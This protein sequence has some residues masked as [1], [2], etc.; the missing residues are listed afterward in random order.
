MNISEF[1]E[2][3]D[4]EFPG[5][6]VILSRLGNGLFLFRDVTRNV[7][8]EYKFRA[9]VSKLR[10]RPDHVFFK[11]HGERVLEYQEILDR[12][13]PNRFRV[14]SF[15]GV[16]QSLKIEFMDVARNLVVHQTLASIKR[17]LGSD[18]EYLF[19]PTSK[20]A[21]EKY[22]NTC[23]EKYGVDSYSATDEFKGKYEA[24]SVAKFGV[25]H[26]TKNPDVAA[27]ISSS[28]NYDQMV[29]SATKSN[30]DRL[31]VTHPMKLLEHRKKVFA[32]F[33]EKY[34]VS[35]PIHVPGAMDKS[36]RTRIES[37]QIR[38]HDGLTFRQIA[39]MYD[40]PIS[41]VRRSFKLNPETAIDRIKSYTPG[42]SSL[43]GLV[44][45]WFIDVPSILDRKIPLSN[46]RPDILFDGKVIVECDGLF[47]HSELSANATWKPDRLY[48][49]N[50]LL[51]Y[52]SLGYRALFFR[53]D[54]I[55]KKPDIVKSIISNALGRNLVKVH[56]RKCSITDSVDKNFFVSNHLMG[57]GSGRSFGLV[58]DGV[59]VSA[60]RVKNV[61]DGGL[62]VSRF[63]NMSLTTVNGA[64][65]RLIGH[66]SVRQTTRKHCRGL[67]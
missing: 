27:K 22:I 63:C 5:R 3:L 59:V 52:E 41:F 15:H 65:S 21:R 23:L 53:S 67:S 18:S 62:D 61:G 31:G 57:P 43:A 38:T 12:L 35:N 66:V 4:S 24:T 45:S 7:E 2:K 37:G 44:S 42:G 11:T 28:V 34:G 32:S 25:T 6:Y 10:D 50:K 39:E 17:K 54:E 9:L 8:F 64:Y 60:I 26:P 29:A 58:H 49:S 1:Q 46:R 16:G 33:D 56:A 13:A 14:I 55:F 40:V 51:E 47:W 36:I 20:E 30:M 19:S 48:H